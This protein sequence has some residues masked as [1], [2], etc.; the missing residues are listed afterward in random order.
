MSSRDRTEASLSVR[1]R[2]E[3]PFGRRQLEGLARGRGVATLGDEV[4]GFV[5]GC[6][7]RIE[8][9]YT[10]GQET[11]DDPTRLEDVGLQQSTISRMLRRSSTRRMTAQSYLVSRID[12]GPRER[13]PLGTSSKLGTLAEITFHASSRRFASTRRLRVGVEIVC[14]VPGSLSWK[15]NRPFFQRARS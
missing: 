1:M 13:H 6:S 10:D 8:T 11:V 5:P 15:S 9:Q 7:G 3:D 14:S 4:E 2:Q 12:S